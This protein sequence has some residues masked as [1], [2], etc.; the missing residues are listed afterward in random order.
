GQVEKT[1]VGKAICDKE[2]IN[3]CINKFINYSYYAYEDEMKNGYITLSGGHRV[4]ICGHIVAENGKVHL[5]R[6]ISS[7]NIRHAREFPGIAEGLADKITAADGRIESTLIVSPPRCGKTTLVRDIVRTLS[8]RGYVVGVCD[9]RSEIAGMRDGM[10]SFDIGANTDV[11]DACPKAEGMLMLLRSMGPD[12]I[13]T[14]EIGKEEDIEAIE[15][16]LL[17]GISIIATVHGAGRRDIAESRISHL[18]E[19]G[20]FKN[21]VFL[22]NRPQIGSVRQIIHINEGRTN[23]AYD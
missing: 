12:V 19:K 11:M 14:D 3:E 20:I 23:C 7:V 22:G 2:I 4:G 1:A 10:P 8:N 21:I 17:A 6:N 15:S 9:E 18:I 16:V 5:M 13:V